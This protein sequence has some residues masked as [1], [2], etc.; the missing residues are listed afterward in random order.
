MVERIA[1]SYRTWLATHLPAA[2]AHR[3][4]FDHGD[5][6][7]DSLYPPHQAKVDA[8]VA[9]KGYRR[10]VDWISRSFPGT[11]HNE[12]DWRVRMEGPLRFLLRA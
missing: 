2:G 4:Y 10:D 3:L 9:A 6:G 11:D 7:L 1:A 8:L 5:Q 12:R